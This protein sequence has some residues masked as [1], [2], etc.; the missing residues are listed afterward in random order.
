[1]FVA[2]SGKRPADQRQV[3]RAYGALRAQLGIRQDRDGQRR[4]QGERANHHDQF[5]SG[6]AVASAG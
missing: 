1:M 6:E 2:P 5:P 4:Q 3:V